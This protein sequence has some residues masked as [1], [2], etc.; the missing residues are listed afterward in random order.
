M[1][2]LRYIVK[3]ERVRERICME[4]YFKQREK[5]ETSLQILT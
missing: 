1:L 5:G 2:Q 3:R 4:N